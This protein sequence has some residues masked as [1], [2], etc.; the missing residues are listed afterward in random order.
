MTADLELLTRS[1]CHLCDEALARLRSAGLA[2]AVVDVDLDL[3]LLAEFDHRVPV[4]RLASTGEVVA[5]G[6]I[7]D[8]VI[9]DRVGP[10]LADC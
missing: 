1:G 9:R 2:P 4:L 7:D 10:R 5:E 3:A 8:A 6:V